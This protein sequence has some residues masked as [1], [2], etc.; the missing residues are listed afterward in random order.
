M[1]DNQEYNN[2]NHKPFGFLAGML[3]G[4]LVGAVTM[5][6]LAPKSG[7]D[8]RKQIREK[9]SQLYGQATDMVEDTV[10]QGR[11]NLEDISSDGR[12]KIK[13]LKQHGQKLAIKQLDHLSKATKAGKKAI[14]NA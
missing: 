14:Q 8:T 10:A 6:L 9:S 11:S 4:G 12:D 2:P 7:K 1:T 13:E 3:T 5:L